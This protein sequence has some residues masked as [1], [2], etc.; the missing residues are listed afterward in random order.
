MI[1]RTGGHEFVPLR[2]N[3]NQY[4]R[5]GLTKE[6]YKNISAIDSQASGVIASPVELPDGRQKERLII[7]G[8]IEEAISSS[9]LEGASTSREVAKEMLR[10]QRQP[11]DES[12]QMIFNNYIA[13]TKVE[14]CLLYTSPSPRDQRGS[15]MPSSA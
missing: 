5:L 13:M 15:R 10:T 1:K 7:S 9:Q 12:E 3:N 11:R 6:H 14:D 2:T 4:F 8:L